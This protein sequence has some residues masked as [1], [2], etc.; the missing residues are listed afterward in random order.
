MGAIFQASGRAK[1][2]QCSAEVKARW[3][4][5]LP[6]AMMIL[7]R[8]FGAAPQFYTFPEV[9]WPRLRTANGLERFHAEVKRRIRAVGAF[10]DRASALRLVTAVALRATEAWASRRYMD[11]S[12]LEDKTEGPVRPA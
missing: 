8:G 9:H 7:E 3:T 4:Q 10:P 6:E 1:A 5:E 11:L 12:L 2:K